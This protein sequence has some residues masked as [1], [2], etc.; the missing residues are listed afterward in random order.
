MQ[1]NIFTQETCK[2]KIVSI[3]L[4]RKMDVRLKILKGAEELI[5]R[6][7]IKNITMDD[8]AKSIS[9]SKKTIY[10]HFKEKDEVIHSLMQLSIEEDKACFS[11]IKDGSKNVVEE[12]FEMM[13]SMREIFSKLNPVVFYELSRYY[14]NTW[15]LFLEFKN[16][17]ILSMVEQSLLRGQQQGFIRKD[18]DVKLLAKLR[19]ET[20]EML[21]NTQFVS[22]VKSNLADAQIAV[23]EHF[24]YGVCTL[25][26]HR[27]INKYKNLIEEE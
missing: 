19:V 18:I 5:F 24:L 11:Q 25:K 3:V 23:T 12:V 26:G 15:K 20:I 6:Y 16:G 14:P 10:K 4:C 9:V 8:I 21:L 1:K 27:L 17:Y 22:E 7:G 2:T 13:K